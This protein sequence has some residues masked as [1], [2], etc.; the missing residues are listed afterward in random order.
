MI[1]NM[2]ISNLPNILITG[3]SGLLGSALSERL[4]AK[5]YGVFHLSR[6]PKKRTDGVKVFQWDLQKQSV[7]EAAFEGVETIIHLAGAGVADK[8]WTDKRKKEIIDSRV[9]SARLLETFLKEKTHNVQTFV[10]AS[11]VGYYGDRGMTI[12]KET[13]APANDFLAETCIKWEAASEGI[14]AMGIRRVVFRIGIVLTKEGGALPKM[15]MPVKMGLGNYLGDGKQVYSWIHLE[16]L[17]RLFVYAVE[18]NSFQGIYNAVAPNPLNNKIFT[19]I[20]CKVLNRLFLPIP[21][22]KFALKMALG[23]LSEVLLFSTN[24]SAEKAINAGFEFRFKELE[25]ALR[26][27]Y[28]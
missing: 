22:P 15:A 28:K 10:S 9:D 2:A 27:L 20:L 6:K 7:E 1:K 13:A 18:Q 23:Q 14:E 16:D 26:D 5:G 21:V 19:K 12:L 25:E 17:C 8:R 11:G 3:G 24:A 4:L